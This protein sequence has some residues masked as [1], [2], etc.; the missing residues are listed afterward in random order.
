VHVI[1]FTRSIRSSISSSGVGVAS[2]SIGV[3]SSSI[4]VASSG[5][6][7]SVSC[8]LSG[9]STAG[10]T[11]LSW[12]SLSGRNCDALFLVWVVASCVTSLSVRGS[13]VAAWLDVRFVDH[14]FI[15]LSVVWMIVLPLNSGFFA[16]IDILVVCDMGVVLT[17]RGIGFSFDENSWSFD[18]GCWSRGVFMDSWFTIDNAGFTS[19]IVNRWSGLNIVAWSVLL[20][21]NWDT[22][23]LVMVIILD[24]LLF[25]GVFT[26]GFWAAFLETLTA[27]GAS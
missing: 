26:A 15:C 23:L 14:N 7:S 16:P 27:W 21:V 24:Y 19:F 18:L 22:F 11:N 5:I 1:S 8:I 3:A 10:D 2:S 4:G 9:S 17:S 20:N 25:V 12:S 13:T 6:T